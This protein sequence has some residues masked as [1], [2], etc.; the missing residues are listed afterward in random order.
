[1]IVSGEERPYI[2]HD[3]RNVK[4]FFGDYRWLSNF[5]ACD[6]WY[7]GVKYPSTENAYQAAKIIDLKAR[8]PFALMTAAES[9]KASKAILVRDDWNEI[10]YDVMS[11]LSFQKYCNHLDLRQALLDTG[12]KY[13]EESNHWKDVYWG[14]CNGNGDN[15][16]GKILMRVRKFWQEEKR[17]DSTQLF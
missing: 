9:K 8:E 16:L 7:E 17:T 1:M 11:L 5:E 15:N 12:E 4:G 10:K 6:I 3:E 14:V 13:L 2:I